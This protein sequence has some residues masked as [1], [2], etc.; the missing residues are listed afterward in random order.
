MPTVNPLRYYSLSVPWV[1]G[2]RTEWHPAEPAGPF[3][4]LSRGAFATVA[5]AIAWG[6]AHL[7]GAPYTVVLYTP[8]GAERLTSGEA[9]AAAIAG[10]AP[11]P[12]PEA[13]PPAPEAPPAPAP[14]PEAPTAAP[15]PAELYFVLPPDPCPDGCGTV[16]G[17]CA[18][19]LARQGAT[20]PPPPEAPPPEAPPPA[21]D[22]VRLSPRAVADARGYRARRGARVPSFNVIRNHYGLSRDRG[23]LGPVP[24]ELDLDALAAYARIFRAVCGDT[25]V[26]VPDGERP[27]TK[28]RIRI[29]GR[30]L[31]SL[32][33][34]PGGAVLT[35]DKAAAGLFDGPVRLNAADHASPAMT[36]GLARD[37][38]KHDAKAWCEPVDGGPGFWAT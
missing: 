19:E 33:C 4:T 26:R 21:L 37:L 27:R 16:G 1:P 28:Y 20:P 32:V 25:D 2:P 24:A 12:A 17:V 3:A 38:L 15:A 7:A 14:A 22:F 23:H 5:D 34:K 30:W 31:A 9:M 10:E 11:P 8:E 6:V 13:P 35:D 18:F 36:T 29:A